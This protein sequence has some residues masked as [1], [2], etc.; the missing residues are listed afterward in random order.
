MIVTS[1]RHFSRTRDVSEAAV[2]KP[3]RRN[4]TYTGIPLV[5]GDTTDCIFHK[6]ANGYL[7][8][9][10]NA[11]GKPVRAWHDNSS[12][13]PI[14]AKSLE[15]K[16]FPDKII[17]I[18]PRKLYLNDAVPLRGVLLGSSLPADG[19]NEKTL[20]IPYQRSLLDQLASLRNSK[21]DIFNNYKPSDPSRTDDGERNRF[22]KKRRIKK[23]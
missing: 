11:E 15:L 12:V 8:I 6:H 13:T 3:R 7:L 2:R 10:L 23:N 20:L 19:P 4:L 18:G 16:K 9:E 17:G 22:D 21:D 1:V 5:S 14:R